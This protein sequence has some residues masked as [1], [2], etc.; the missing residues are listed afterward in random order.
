MKA[1]CLRARGIFLMEIGVM[2]MLTEA[3]IVF[4]GY[5]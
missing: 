3:G 5:F 4:C 1:G 2:K